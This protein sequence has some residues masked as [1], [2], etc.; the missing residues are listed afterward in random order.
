[1]TSGGNWSEG[2]LDDDIDSGVLS[3]REVV[4]FLETQIDLS[5]KDNFQGPK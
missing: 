3:C 4:L 5:T 1:M 2:T